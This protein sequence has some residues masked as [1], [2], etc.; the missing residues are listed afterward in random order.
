MENNNN[1]LKNKKQRATGAASKSYY[2]VD[3]GVLYASGRR[4]A[5][6]ITKIAKIKFNPINLPN[7]F[8]NNM[9]D[10]LQMN[11]PIANVGLTENEQNILLNGIPKA[12]HCIGAAEDV[13]QQ[14]LDADWQA[15]LDTN[16]GLTNPSK[17]RI[18]TTTV[19]LTF[20]RCQMLKKDAFEFFLRARPGFTYFLCS[21]EKH[22]DGTDHLHIF[23]Q[24]KLQV[25]TTNPRY[26]DMTC[27]VSGVFYHG[28]YQS[29]VKPDCVIDYI[30]KYD[31]DCFTFGIYNSMDK[32]DIAKRALENKI[33]LAS[34]VP[35]LIDDGIIA[36]RDAPQYDKAKTLYTLQKNTV[37]DRI[38]RI[39]IWIYGA[40]GS[41]KSLYVRDNFH[42][43]F[44]SKPLNKWWDNY[45]S[46]QKIVL[47][48]DVGLQHDWMFDLLKIWADDYSFT[49]EVKG[50]A[51]KPNYNIVL[52]TSQ[53]LP[54]DI[55]CKGTDP[56]NWNT[57]AQ[58][59][60]ERRFLI[61]KVNQFGSL[62]LYQEPHKA[63]LWATNLHVND[64]ID[65]ASLFVS[66]RDDFKRRQEIDSVKLSKVKDSWTELFK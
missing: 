11:L 25:N 5:K 7:T 63:N 10:E 24:Y 66:K 56:N 64:T 29:A 31:E 22:K 2:D 42:E 4:G 34:S 21:Q 45:L 32:S 26:F 60:I 58:D 37:E 49:A 27:P 33:K 18:H 1:L 15:R 65:I 6:K 17:F 36:L 47:L 20:P 39:S 19:F 55:I 16:I 12:V 52:V 51:V 54:K 3:A 61:C 59:A 41:G 8:V 57:E 48:D 23:I 62:Y 46:T 28:N 35:E 44:F 50:A 9:E 40:A 38:A 53:F 14:R 43:S 30:T 13:R